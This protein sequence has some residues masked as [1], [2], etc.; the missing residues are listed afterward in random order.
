MYYDPAGFDG[1][2]NTFEEARKT[3]KNITYTANTLPVGIT[4][5]GN[6]ISGT[7]IVA[8][9]IT[10][11][12]TATAAI[13]NKF[14]TRILNWIITGGDTYFK[15]VSLLLKTTATSTPNNIIFLPPNGLS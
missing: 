11:L 7:P 5:T 10:S 9:T 12:I 3:N 13:T 14:A 8:S 2:K 4:L 1:I 15:Y 6:T